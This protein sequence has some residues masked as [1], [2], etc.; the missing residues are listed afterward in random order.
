MNLAPID[1]P[2]PSTWKSKIASGPHLQ[3]P[4]LIAQSC[5]FVPSY[6]RV[7]F[8]LEFAKN[9]NRNHYFIPFFPLHEQKGKCFLGFT[10]IF[11]INPHFMGHFSIR[12]TRSLLKPIWADTFEQSAQLYIKVDAL[13][14]SEM[15]MI[16]IYWYFQMPHFLWYLDWEPIDFQNSSIFH[17]LKSDWPIF[18]SVIFSAVTSISS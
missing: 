12:Q 3:V 1:D 8:L 6:G 10:L 7:S 5:N 17:D 2:H 15:K 16:F 4:T 9:K 14:S 11:M 13:P 18:R